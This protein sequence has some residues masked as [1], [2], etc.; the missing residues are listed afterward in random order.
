MKRAF[1]LLTLIALSVAA[2]GA[3]Q[4]TDPLDDLF[5]RGRAAQAGVN[6]VAASF[7]ETTKSS[8]LRE[9]L[10]ARGTLI[11]AKPLRVLMNYTS[12]TAKVIRLDETTLVVAW[13]GRSGREEIN[14]AE[15]QRRVQTY[16][17]DA[18]AGELRKSFDI[19]LSP[20][21]DLAEAYRLDMIPKRKQIREGLVALHVWIDRTTL[22]LVKM[23]MDYPGGDSRTL[24]LKDIRLNVPITD[25]TFALPGGGPPF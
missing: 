24:E 12:P 18:S 25:R 14:I 3:V 6:S 2:L 19:A 4:K 9:P 21:P 15:T 5:R 13:P 22:V 16:F 1:G 20:D 23:V 8:L 17:V 7:V 11:A 10:V